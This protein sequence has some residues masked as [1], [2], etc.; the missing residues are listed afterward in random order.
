[1]SNPQVARTRRAVLEAA[2][3]L[4]RERGVSGMTIDGVSSRS[5]VARSTIYRHW[6]DLP[7]LTVDAFAALAGPPPQ[8]PDSGDV[9]TDLV[10]LFGG[11]ARG[12]KTVPSLRVLPSLADVA[13]RD[14]VMS[15]LLTR[16]IDA[17]RQPARE[18]VRRAVERGQVRADVNVEWLL[19]AI[20]GPLFYRQM[21]SRRAPDE[22]GLVEQLVD[23]A[24]AAWAPDR[25]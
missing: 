15:D 6:A 25:S 5:Q 23:A 13:Q 1:M 22:P 8:V 14:P 7:A 2:A 21:V 10:A 4:L 19:D 9:R 11:L 24:L 18:V 12:I 17:Q 20:G 16:F 3:E